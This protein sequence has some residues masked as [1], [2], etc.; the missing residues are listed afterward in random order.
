MEG[1]EFMKTHPAMRDDRVS[2]PS[3]AGEFEQ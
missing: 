3:E 1:V 2:W